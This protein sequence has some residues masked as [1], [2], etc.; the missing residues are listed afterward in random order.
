VQDLLL[1][2]SDVLGAPFGTAYPPLLLAAFEATQSI[3]INCWPRMTVYRAEI[4]RG[5]VMCW[6]KVA[7][8]GPPGSEAIKTAIKDTIK[9]LTA[10]VGE[11]VVAKADQ[12]NLIH[13]DKRLSELFQ[14]QL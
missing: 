4:L 12:D 9:L 14:P 13:A 1:L 5:L 7:E 6:C 3:I 2:L 10:A 8:D 11:P